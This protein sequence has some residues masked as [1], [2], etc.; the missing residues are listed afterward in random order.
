MPAICSGLV[1]T[2]RQRDEGVCS[3]LWRGCL[4]LGLFAAVLVE[5]DGDLYQAMDD[6]GRLWC[7]NSVQQGE[8][9][10]R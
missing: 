2:A 1:F 7:C 6:G 9:F 10:S 4:G 5:R 8:G 3:C